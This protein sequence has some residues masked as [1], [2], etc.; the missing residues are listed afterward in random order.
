MRKRT[1]KILEERISYLESLVVDNRKTLLRLMSKMEEIVKFLNN[2]ISDSDAEFG[3]AADQLYETIEQ[4]KEME[5]ELKKY[6][7]LIT[8]DNFGES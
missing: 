7:G 5:K 3:M 2:N 6:N 8:V 4:L 1:V